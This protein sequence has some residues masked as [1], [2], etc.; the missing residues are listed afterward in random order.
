MCT[1]STRRL[2][3]IS[4]LGIYSVCPIQQTA[5]RGPR[6]GQALQLLRIQSRNFRRDPEATKAAEALCLRL[7][8]GAASWDPSQDVHSTKPV[9]YTMLASSLAKSQVPAGKPFTNR[10]ASE[11]FDH[12]LAGFE[13]FGV[14]LTYLMCELSR[15]QDVQHE[16][17]AELL[18]H[19]SSSAYKDSM[20]STRAA[21]LP[22]QIRPSLML[23]PSSMPSF[24]RRFGCIKHRQDQNRA[25]RLQEGR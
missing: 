18:Q 16:L 15:R 11:M 8:Q 13:T 20:K 4:Y 19:C 21:N 14:T 24:M 22:C 7:C 12:L 5:S 1:S 25:G 2:V 6:N 10:I 3:W 9:V 23:F 17:R